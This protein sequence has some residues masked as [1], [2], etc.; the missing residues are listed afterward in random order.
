MKRFAPIAA[1]AA[2]LLPL[3]ASAAARDDLAA[4]TRGLKG[5]D[6]QFSQKV[7]NADGKLKESTTGR[8]AMS[9]PR[10]FRWEYKQPHPQLIVADGKKVWVYDP[11]LQQA[12]V[13]PQGVEEQ[14]SPLAALI[15]PGK[16]DRD[17][18]V[19]E[20][21]NAD[22]LEWLLLSPK[23]EDQASF[24]SA[25]LGFG[26]NGLAKMQIV[27]MLGQRTEISFEGWKRNPSFAAGTFAYKPPQGVD[28]IGEE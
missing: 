26:R 27:D 8:V 12:T 18:R 11:D 4:F 5:L 15:D 9:A 20:A 13:R 21:G 16:L 3:A 2:I 1:A 6:G 17:F 28:V 14:N 24:Q 25:K 22:G 10:L 23:V 7:F 19:A